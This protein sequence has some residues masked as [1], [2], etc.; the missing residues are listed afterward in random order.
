M[1]KK[2]TRTTEWDSP[3]KIERELRRIMEL[4]RIEL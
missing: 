2:V 4:E 3:E 1:A